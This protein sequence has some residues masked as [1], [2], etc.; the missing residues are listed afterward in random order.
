M[1][2]SDTITIMC[3]S[4]GVVANQA[5][6]GCHMHTISHTRSQARVTFAVVQQW[7]AHRTLQHWSAVGKTGSR[8]R[9]TKLCTGGL[10]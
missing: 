2:D 3:N 10:R 7:L 9:R 1:F 6:N 5:E 4:A 8:R